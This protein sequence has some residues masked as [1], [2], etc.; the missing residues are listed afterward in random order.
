MSVPYLGEI[1][2]WGGNF[3]PVSWEFCNGQLLSIAQFDALFALIGT[4]YGGDGVNDFGLP[5]LQ[6]RVP[7]HQGPNYVIGQ[8]AGVEEVT[9][10]SAQMP[11]H[12]HTVNASASTAT[13]TSPTGAT[14]APWGD[15]PYS[16]GS[17]NSTLNPSALTAAGSSLPHENMPPFL[18]ITFIIAVEGIFPSFS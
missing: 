1:R 18:A 10:T 2:M 15:E 11:I 14:W 8:M 13:S 3:A 12:Q 16:T 17:P 6:S 9:L 7:V 5:N 4:T